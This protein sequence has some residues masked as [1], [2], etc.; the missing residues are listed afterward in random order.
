MKRLAFMTLVVL[1]LAN[2]VSAQSP[3]DLANDISQKIMSPF[4]P[5]VTLHDCPSQSAL[6]MRDR[7]EGYARS[8]MS[9]DAIMDRLEA[10]YGAA[11]RAEP[12]SE[13]AGLVAWILPGLGAIAGGALAVIVVRRWSA[14]S[15]QRLG[16]DPEE[17]KPVES[18]A[19]ERQRLD[20]ELGQLRGES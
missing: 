16:R 5:G 10:E 13:G 9:E 7:I 19:S 8:G 1:A 11:I 6:E 20:A 18:S 17:P 14:R 2:P 15:P 3:E 12:S 4:C